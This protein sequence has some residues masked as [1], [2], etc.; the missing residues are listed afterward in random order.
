MKAKVVSIVGPTAVGK[1]E[2]SIQLAKTFRAE[3]ISGDAMQVYRGLNI[4]TAK[5]TPEEQQNIPHYMI[6]IK[7]PDESFSVAEFQQHI[8]DY[9]QHIWNKGALPLIV[10]GSGLYVQAALYDYQ[11][12]NQKRDE[13]FT[14]EME[15]IIAKQGIDP[16]YQ[17][18]KKIDPKHARS[19][20][21]NNH[22]RVI[23]AL[24][25]YE[26]TGKTMTEIQK[27][28]SEKPLYDVKFIG[29]NMDRN[30]LYERINK[31]VDYMIE[32]GLLEEVKGL[33]DKGYE[34]NQAM[35]AI[36]YKEF[37][38]YFEG[39]QSFH[40]AVE[41]LKR[42]S[43]R[44]AKRQLTWFRNRLPVCWYK[45]T[46]SNRTKQYQKIIEDVAGFLKEK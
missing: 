28:Q 36:G 5:I 24:E 15:N 39:E 40:A 13:Q 21:P 38:P 25:I 43:R 31:R 22:R 44:Y 33:Y 26:T 23:R 16:L 12:T 30:L 19:I 45:L 10:G 27:K 37:I 4:G 34:A 42:N 1:T 29:L 41:T 8:R 18:L 46:P 9:I 35:Q 6:D 32:Q 3:I 14:K 11:F 20:H 2:L 7:E 17:K